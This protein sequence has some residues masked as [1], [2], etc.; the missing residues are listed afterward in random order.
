MSAI[1]NLRA[2]PWFTFCYA[3]KLD[4]HGGHNKSV[5][6]QAKPQFENLLFGS[7]NITPDKVR[8]YFGGH[9]HGIR[10]CDKYINID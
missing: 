9:H 5:Q 10:L 8:R 6:D 7:I 1:F 3:K 4:K 2:V